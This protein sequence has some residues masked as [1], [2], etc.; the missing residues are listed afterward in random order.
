MVTSPVVDTEDLGKG[1]HP[2]GH[3]FCTGRG[4]EPQRQWAGGVNVEAFFGQQISVGRDPETR[5]PTSFSFKD[6]THEVARIMTAWQDYGFPN[7]GRK[8]TWRQR[9]HRNYYRV[10]TSEG[11]K[12][13]ILLRQGRLDGQSQVHALVRDKRALTL[14]ILVTY[15]DGIN[16]EGLWTLVE[17]LTSVGEVSVVAPDR[18]QSGIGTAR[19][20]LNIL[21]VSEVETRIE[22]VPAYTVSGT[23]SDCVV[24]AFEAIFDETFDLVVSGINEGANLGLDVLDSGTVGGALR[25]YFRGIPSIAVSV[26]SVTG[27]IYGPA[28]QVAKSLAAYVVESGDRPLLYNVNVPNVPAERLKGARARRTWDRRRTWRRWSGGATGDALTTGFDTTGRRARTCR[29]DATFGRRG[30]GG[31]R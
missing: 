6:E 9:H 20:L 16:A 13:E 3:V 30:T 28:A 7:D 5:E 18:D 10:E 4:R 14:R 15:D 12:F 21:R 11:R 23:P 25:G 26:T 29:R 19:T 2:N 22:G 1:E 27:V 31:S 24:L 17:S 8:H